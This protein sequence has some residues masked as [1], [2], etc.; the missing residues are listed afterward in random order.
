MLVILKVMNPKFSKI[1]KSSMIEIGRVKCK[2]RGAW[3]AQSVKHLPSAQV[4]ILESWD[5]AS[6]LLSGE[7]ASLF[8]S[9]LHATHALSLSLFL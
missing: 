2:P 7:S 3:V 1:K 6:Y 4:M 9:A 8:P 5:R